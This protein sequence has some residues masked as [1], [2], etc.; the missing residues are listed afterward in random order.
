MRQNLVYSDLLKKKKRIKHEE[1]TI[2]LFEK[3]EPKQPE[4][5]KFENETKCYTCILC[6]T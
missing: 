3:V 1:V 6:Y 5:Y 4:Q 2:F